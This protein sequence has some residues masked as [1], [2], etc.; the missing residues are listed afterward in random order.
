MSPCAFVLGPGVTFDPTQGRGPQMNLASHPRKKKAHLKQGRMLLHILSRSM[1]VKN[2][3][4]P[5]RFSRLPDVLSSFSPGFSFFFL[6]S[7]AISVRSVSKQ[8]VTKLLSLRSVFPS[9]NNRYNG[10]WE[11]GREALEDI[12][13]R[14]QLELYSQPLLVRPHTYLRPKDLL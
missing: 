5:R 2:H 11:L 9:L 10:E 3:L 8:L 14:S 6:S 4:D 12:L 7:F 13:Y 1:R